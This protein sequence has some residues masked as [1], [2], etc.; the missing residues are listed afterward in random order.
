MGGGPSKDAGGGESKGDDGAAEGGEFKAAMRAFA[1]ATTKAELMDAISRLESAWYPGIMPNSELLL[2]IA[3][4][5]GKASTARSGEEA[6]WDADAAV[7][8]DALAAFL[9]V[10]ELSKAEA[11]RALR[12]EVARFDRALAVEGLQH[13]TVVHTVISILRSVPDDA[14]LASEALEFLG[15][16][17]RSDD[18]VAACFEANG[19]LPV[20]L[21]A[22]RTFPD[23][24]IVAR[25]AIQVLFHVS[26][27][28]AGRVT[29]ARL[30]G[31]TDL[32]AAV[33][34]H[35]TGDAELV[36]E[37]N[38]V[39]AHMIAGAEGK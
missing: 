8:I 11:L 4:K 38:A 27:T 23:S 32:R 29:L 34:R 1:E 39:A 12:D 15:Y 14:K 19:G 21:A 35:G 5:R 2:A 37:A 18:E 16:A 24:D 3:D 28:E 33:E 31:V 17:C 26:R 36:K 10:P 9:H 6:V 7:R 13:V 22:L 30:R 25:R 20:V